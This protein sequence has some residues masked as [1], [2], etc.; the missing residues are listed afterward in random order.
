[1]ADNLDP[2]IAL[3]IDNVLTLLE[4]F[5]YPIPQLLRSMWSLNDP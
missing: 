3:Y 4:S 1:M 5:R 2:N